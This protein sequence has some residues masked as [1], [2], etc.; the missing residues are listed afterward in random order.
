MSGTDNKRLTELG[1]ILDLQLRATGGTYVADNEQLCFDAS[2]QWTR[3]NDSL[4]EHSHA[5]VCDAA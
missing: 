5:A 2:I 4:L 1:N 3:R